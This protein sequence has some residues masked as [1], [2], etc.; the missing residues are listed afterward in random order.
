MVLRKS[1]ATYFQLKR[2]NPTEENALAPQHPIQLVFTEKEKTFDPK[3]VYG[4]APNQT[5]S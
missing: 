2:L 1:R 4:D 5:K 3:I